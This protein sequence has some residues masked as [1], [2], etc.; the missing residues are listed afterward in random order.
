M[1]ITYMKAPKKIIDSKTKLQRCCYHKV[2]NGKV[3]KSK[4]YIQKRTNGKCKYLIQS[5]GSYFKNSNGNS[6]ESYD[7]E[8]ESLPNSISSFT[9][10]SRSLS[11]TNSRS[12][13]RSSNIYSKRRAWQNTID[14]GNEDK[15]EEEDE[16][17][18]GELKMREDNKMKL[19]EERKKKSISKASSILGYTN[20]ERSNK[21]SINKLKKLAGQ[22]NVG[23]NL[24]ITKITGE[25]STTRKYIL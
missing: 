2:V 19:K 18:E 7:V 3:D 13:S 25:N 4:M 12:S 20:I 9:N 16:K 5:G 24:K 23:N 8:T 6:Y 22:T 21:N 11:N 10:S 1:P 15:E 14:E 17:R